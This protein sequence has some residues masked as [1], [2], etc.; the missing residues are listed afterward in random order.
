MEI[1]ALIPSVANG[2]ET[3]SYIVK[4][5]R[6]E[7]AALAVLARYGEIP[8]KGREKPKRSDELQV[9]DIVD[10]SVAIDAAA[11]LAAFSASREEVKKSTAVLRGALT[12]I[13]NTMAQIVAPKEE[14]P[15]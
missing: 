5:H 15:K 2:R 6:C 9:G 10:C 7:L 14:Q 3:D 8:V 1:I 4:L 13:E 11:E 12:R